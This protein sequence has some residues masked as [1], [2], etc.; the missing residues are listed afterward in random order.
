MSFGIEIGLNDA[1]WE[2]V[3]NFAEDVVDTAT[4]IVEDVVDTVT[5]IVEDVVDFIGDVG[6]TIGNGLTQAWNWITSW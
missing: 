3:K 4:E 6:E 1:G 2:N 5:E